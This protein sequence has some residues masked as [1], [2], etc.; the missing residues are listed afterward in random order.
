MAR[1]PAAGPVYRLHR[2]SG[3][4]VCTVRLPD[5]TRKDLYLGAYDTAEARAEFGRGAAVVA[6]NGG[7]YPADRCELTVNEALVRYGKFIDGYYR[8]PDGRQTGSAD[9]IRVSLGY[10]RRLFG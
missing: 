8:D 7:N 10:L 3:R 6:A 4:A 1:T 5:G 9:D 2:P